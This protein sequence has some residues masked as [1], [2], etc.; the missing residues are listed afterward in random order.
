M[1]LGRPL[2]LALRCLLQGMDMLV[3]NSNLKLVKRMQ[4]QVIMGSLK[5]LLVNSNNSNRLIPN[6]TLSNSRM[7]MREV[8]ELGHMLM[9]GIRNSL[10]LQ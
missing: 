2:H 10:E 4:E 7:G 3:N 8:L 5:L 1:H 6:Y 9:L